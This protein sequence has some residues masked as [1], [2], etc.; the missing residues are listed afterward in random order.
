MGFR[1]VLECVGGLH[2]LTMDTKNKSTVSRKRRNCALVFLGFL[3]ADLTSRFWAPQP[4]NH[5]NWFFEIS[6]APYFF[7]IY[8]CIS[9]WFHFSRKPW[10]PGYPASLLLATYSPIQKWSGYRLAPPTAT[11]PRSPPPLSI[12]RRQQ[13]P[14]LLEMEALPQAYFSVFFFFSIPT[15]TFFFLLCQGFFLSF[16][17]FPPE[18]IVPPINISY[19][20]VFFEAQGKKRD[21][22]PWFRKAGE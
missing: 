22:F 5:M 15:P 14:E 18:E 16:S 17:F 21:N 1:F 3:A 19:G 9:Y 4:C 13:R 7:L 2:P 20:K 11:Q 10:L 8:L 12:P 6:P